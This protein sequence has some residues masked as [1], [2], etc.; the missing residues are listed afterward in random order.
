MLYLY[1]NILLLSFLSGF[2]TF[3]GVIFAIRF[4]KQTRGIVVGLGFSAGIMILLS[5]FN[6][7]PE[8]LSASTTYLSMLFLVF[9]LGMVGALD[10]IIPHTHL[11]QQDDETSH[12]LKTAYL[13][14]F[15]IIIHDVP[16]GF[17]MANSYVYS[18]VIGF[19]I[20]ISIAIHNVSEEFAMAIP[21]VSAKSRGF[22]YK[23]AFFSGLAEPLGAIIGIAAV[24]FVPQFT[25]YFMALAAG[26]MLYVGI[27]ELSSFALQYKKPYFFGLG[28]LLSVIMYV[29][30]TVWIPV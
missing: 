6:L 19:L 30:L 13:I 12:A 15:A 2:T 20:A 22:L 18:P 16:E 21:V 14:A 17:A 28:G 4:E 11:V 7:I 24:D 25:P 23:V 5:V 29:I 9:G 8:A 27:H 1:F 3:I 10:Y 26:A